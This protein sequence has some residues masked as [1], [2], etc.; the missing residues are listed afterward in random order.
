MFEQLAISIASIKDV[1]TIINLSE[2]FKRMKYNFGITMLTLLLVSNMT[3]ANEQ[4][5]RTSYYRQNIAP[6]LFFDENNRPTSGILFDITHAI[7][8]RLGVKLEMLAIPRKRIQQSLVKNIIDMHCV[9]NPKWYTLRSLQWSSVIYK[10][11]DILINNEGM[12]SLTDLAEHNNLKIGTTL[13]YIYPELSVYINN[14]NILPVTSVSPADNY[15]KYRKNNL[16]GFIIPEIEASYFFKETTDAVILLND[17]DIHCVLAPSMK[18][19]RVMRISN[20]VEQLKA[21][22]KVDA[23]LKKYKSVPTPPRQH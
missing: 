5:L 10:N 4:N 17:N 7:A 6:Q 18:K 11:P 12:T 23:I 20:A 13:G 3:I 14:R 8:N 1:R 9:A 19:S 16:S 22:G 2:V 15:K 21:S